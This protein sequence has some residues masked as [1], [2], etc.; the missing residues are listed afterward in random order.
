M[1]QNRDPA[2]WR[3]FSLAIHLDEES[4]ASTPE[5]EEVSLWSDNWIKDQERKRRRMILCGFLIFFLTA[6]FVVGVIV[7]IVWLNAHHW[8]QDAPKAS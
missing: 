6:L 2:F 8:L 3:R 5:K 7:V 1:A 4:K